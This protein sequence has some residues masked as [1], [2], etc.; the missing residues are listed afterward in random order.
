VAKRRKFTAE[1]KLELLK[2][3]D[4]CRAPGELG[5]LLRRERLRNRGG[6]RNSRWRILVNT[7]VDPEA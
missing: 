5:A 1:Y 3:A 6:E 7:E 2:E 4:A